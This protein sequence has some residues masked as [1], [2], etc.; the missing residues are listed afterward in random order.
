MIL[1]DALVAEDRE[2][3]LD[4]RLLLLRHVEFHKG[5]MDVAHYLE[6]VECERNV[7]VWRVKKLVLRLLVHLLH[8]VLE[9][10]WVSVRCS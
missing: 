7:Q 3:L 2:L 9:E 10:I 4:G 6:L 5:C 1:D 8:E